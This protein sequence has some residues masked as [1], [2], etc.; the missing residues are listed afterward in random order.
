MKASTFAA[1]VAGDGSAMYF[2]LDDDAS[3]GT[4][5]QNTT[6]SIP[7]TAKG[8][9]FLRFEHQFLFGAV[10]ESGAE[11][12]YSTDNGKTWRSATDTL[13]DKRGHNSKP[14]LLKGRH[15]FSGLSNGF[16][17]SR[18]NMTALKGKSVKLRFQVKSAG[19]LAIWWVDNVQLYTCR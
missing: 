17:S 10:D 8:S 13:P 2:P 6:W 4:L 3:S 7:K 14:T 1:A 16:G 15:G 12:L 19:G 9:V 11:L 5:T 18:Y